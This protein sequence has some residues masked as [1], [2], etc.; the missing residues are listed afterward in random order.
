MLFFR[1][2]ISEIGMNYEVEASKVHHSMPNSSST[3][4]FCAFALP[5][6]GSF[7][8]NITCLSFKSV[9]NGKDNCS[10]KLNALIT[11]YMDMFKDVTA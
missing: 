7:T 2:L 1:F 6:K 8:L 5:T 4:P 10:I 9:V 3:K 11:E